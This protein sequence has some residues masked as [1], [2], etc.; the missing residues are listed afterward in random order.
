M[1]P[2]VQEKT[3]IIEDSFAASVLNAQA[4]ELSQSL[5]TINQGLRILENTDSALSKLSALLRQSSNLADTVLDDIRSD[6][7]KA[8]EKLGAFEIDFNKNTQAISQFV[9]EFSEKGINL[10]QGDE[11]SI[12]VNQEARP[13]IVEGRHYDSQA[14]GLGSE[15]IKTGEDL[16]AIKNNLRSALDSVQNFSV[17]LRDNISTFQ[18]RQGFT[19]QS[20]EALKEGAK[21]FEVKDLS[22]EGINL[23]ALQTRQ[24]LSDSNVSLASAEQSS[25]LRLF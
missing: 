4:G 24:Q 12:T 18:T 16:H 19:A 5:D 1:S 14:L 9:N 3:R 22:E 25:I 10:L 23:L 11:M 8:P 15:G 20:I 13:F 7:S 17:T 6:T 2:A 21:G